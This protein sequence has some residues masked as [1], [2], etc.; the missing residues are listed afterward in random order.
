MAALASGGT[1]KSTGLYYDVAYYKTTVAA[2]KRYNP[3]IAV[4]RPG[5]VL[6]V[7]PSR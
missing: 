1:P 6:I 7:Q 3:D 5:L 2:L 4:P